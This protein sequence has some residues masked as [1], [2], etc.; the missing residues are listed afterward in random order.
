MPS[1]SDR[2]WQ[3]IEESE[4][5]VLGVA[6]G[7]GFGRSTGLRVSGKI[8]AIRASDELVVKLPKDRVEELVESGAG[9]RWGPG[10]ERVMKEWV[11][12]SSSAAPRW[13]ALVREAREF[14][15]SLV[16]APSD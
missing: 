9:R 14:V 16:P 5:T 8:F 10:E 11:V 12:I 3:S 4:L 15:S 13:P 6:S 2:V 7:T 1:T